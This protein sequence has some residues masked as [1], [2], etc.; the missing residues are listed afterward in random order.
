MEILHAYRERKIYC[1]FLTLFLTCTVVFVSLTY[2]KT[3]FLTRNRM[4]IKIQQKAL[5]LDPESTNLDPRN[6]L[7]HPVIP[8]R[9]LY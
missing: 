4:R 9:H 3:W 8:H 6:C 1:N 2:L 7:L 5:N